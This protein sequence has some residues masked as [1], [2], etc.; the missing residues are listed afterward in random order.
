MLYHWFVRPKWFTKKYIHDHITSQFSFDN[1]SVLDFGC[2]T[3]ANCRMSPAASYL[4]ID[5]DS[6]RIRFASRL[7][8]DY[9]FRALATEVL[10]VDDNSV[11]YVWIIAVLHHLPSDLI[12][13][14]LKEFRRVLKKDG[15]ILVIEPYLCPKTPICNR[16]MQLYD[17]GRYIREEDH[18]LRL[19]DENR[20]SCSIHRKFRKCFLYNEL[21]FSARQ[22]TV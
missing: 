19:F 7:F 6:R 2:G 9:D 12:A 21:F 16:F 20:F 1:Q 22:T 4:G 14:Y 5:P 3:G 15:Q 18:Y 11:D 8:P 17:R 10:P 13:H